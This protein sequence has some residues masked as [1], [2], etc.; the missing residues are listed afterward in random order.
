M[1][2]WLDVLKHFNGIVFFPGTKWSRPETLQLFTDSTGSVKLGC[3]CIP[4][5]Q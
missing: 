5:G 2:K 3:G 1:K 4:R